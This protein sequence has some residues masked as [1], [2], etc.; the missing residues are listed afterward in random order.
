MIGAPDCKNNLIIKYSNLNFFIYK[1]IG[2]YLAGLWEGNGHIVLSIK[3]NYIGITLTN[4]N[5]P[6]IKKLIKNYGGIIRY[7]TKQNA[8]VWIISKKEDLIG[9]VQLINGY[10][11]TPKI[12]QF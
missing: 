5:L 11:R 3:N 7:K 4:K 2:S 1:N 12:Y 8:L 10:L 6:L 9:I